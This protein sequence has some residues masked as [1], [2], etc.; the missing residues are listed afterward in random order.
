MTTDS[1]DDEDLI[2]EKAIDKA[3][4]NPEVKKELAEEEL[5]SLLTAGELRRHL[6]GKREELPEAITAQRQ[7]WQRA[8]H[9]SEGTAGP[10][11]VELRAAGRRW[12]GVVAWI[13]V[14][15]FVVLAGVAI[16]FFIGAILQ[17][18]G[19][20]RTTSGGADWEGGVTFAVLSVVPFLIAGFFFNAAGRSA[21]RRAERRLQTEASRE[22][23][24]ARNY[25]AA[26]LDEQ[27]L[28]EA[29]HKINEVIENA[30][31]RAYDLTLDV[32]GT[33]GLAMYSEYR[34]P[35]TADQ[36]LDGLREQLPGFAVGIA[37]PR[38]VGKTSLLRKHCPAEIYVSEDGRDLSVLASAPVEY[39]PQEFV[40]YLFA[41]LCRA[42][43]EYDKPTGGHQNLRRTAMDLRRSMR[44]GQ[45][46]DASA[47]TLS[48][49][50]QYL[51]QLGY[52]QT[53]NWTSGASLSLPNAIAGLSRQYALSAAEVPLTYPE[54]VSKFRS[55]LGSVAA[56][57]SVN[58]GRV[59][60]G[61]DEL[62]KIGDPDQAQRFINEM[63]AILGVPN[64]SY[65]VTLSDDAL[66]SYEMRGLPVRDAF[67]SAFDEIVHVGYLHLEESRRLLSR[68]VIGMPVPFICLCHCL[69][70]GLP[71]DLIRTARHAVTA[72]QPKGASGH[73]AEVCGQ[74]VIDELASKLH[75]A[76]VRLAGQQLRAADG[77]FLYDLQRIASGQPGPELRDSLAGVRRPPDG[78]KAAADG[79]GAKAAAPVAVISE[80]SAYLEFLRTLLDVFS[81]Q[82]SKELIIAAS[83]AASDEGSFDQLCRIRQTLSTSTEQA[84]LAITAF[85]SAWTSLGNEI[86]NKDSPERPMAD[87]VSNTN[88]QV[89]TMIK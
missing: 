62:D 9:I 86:A 72:T 32:Q 27:V 12:M 50:I 77:K 43:L 21:R 35:G 52:Q 60:I 54:L 55:F 33:S 56:K 25:Y 42:Y 75:A 71:R 61:V 7:R 80:L 37:G 38:G 26:A 83:G 17:G 28:G 31:A 3:L 8:V 51:D 11:L 76:G 53:R 20:I 78:A 81:G 41:T 29:R 79:E 70:G 73:I 74:L 5:K 89:N 65:L 46:I 87:T 36:Y 88:T 47:D 57:V 4:D 22:A 68:R 16:V 23:M 58:K 1:A 85:R 40:R 34:V 15:L 18:V 6:A 39:A 82:L 48:Q 19:A 49:A 59:F 67:D 66:A 69:S 14:I 63:K 30:R 84:M 13:F 45:V 44:K 2:F 64:C 10:L 24:A